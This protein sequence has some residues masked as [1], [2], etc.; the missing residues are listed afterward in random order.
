MSNEKAGSGRRRALEAELSQVADLCERAALELEQINERRATVRATLANHR[1]VIKDLEEQ[2]GVLRQE[3]HTLDR[4]AEQVGFEIRAWR[5][6][7]RDIELRMA[8][9]IGEV[10]PSDARLRPEGGTK[11]CRCRGNNPD[12]VDC[13]GRGYLERRPV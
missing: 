1:N 6:R 3:L 7:G 8:S 11:P 2:V 4:N 10:A 13:G 12:C 5:S 9:D